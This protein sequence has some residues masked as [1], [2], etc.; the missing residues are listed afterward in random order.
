MLQKLCND[1]DVSN[2]GFPFFTIKRISISNIPCVAVRISYI[3]ELGWEIY[4]PTEYGLS[5]W[6]ELREASREFNMICS[7]AGAFESMR[8]EKGY[9]SL[10]TDIHTNTNPYESGL[11]FTVKLK[12]QNDFI[13]K[14]ALQKLKEQPITKKLTCMVLDDPE[15]M[16]L[17]TEPIYK[18]GKVVGYATSTNYGYFVDKHI[19]YGYLPSELSTLG[20]NLELEYFGKRFALTVTN[21]PLLDPENN[22]LKS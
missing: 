2:E 6:D 12:K 20:T 10:G 22:R 9:R 16:A 4:T 14:E 8:L 7:G 11:G 13:G 15:G 3:G 18:D 17:G 21:E 1:D 19:V 5:L